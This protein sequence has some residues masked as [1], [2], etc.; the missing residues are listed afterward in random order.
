MKNFAL[1]AAAAVAVIASVP[2]SAATTVYNANIAAPGVYFGSGNSNGRFAVVTEQGVELGLRGHVYQQSNPIP[3][4][5]LYSF[6]LGE[7]ISFD[8][9]FNAGADGSKLSPLTGVS[10]S[11]TIKNI[12][13][14]ATVNFNPSQVW[15]NATN[16]TY[17]AYQNSW[18]LSFWFIAGLGYNANQNNTYEVSWNYTSD[19]TGALNNTIYLQQG[20]GA[21]PEPASWAM[22]IGGLALVGSAMRRRATKVSFA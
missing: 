3:T 18:R 17:G 6:A 1:V 2:A 9:S 11:I 8:W 22:M 4:G 7:A 5:N 16:S 10:N 20:T 14:G 21:V 15:D 13:S 12:G 19:Q